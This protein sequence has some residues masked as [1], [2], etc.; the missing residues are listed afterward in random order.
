M[1]ASLSVNALQVNFE[2]VL[3]MEHEGMVKMKMV[4]TK[5]AFLVTFQ[6]PTDG[7]VGFTDLPAKEVVERKMVF[8]GTGV[9]F[10]PPNK[11]KD[12]KVEYRLLHDIVSKALYAKADSF[13][14]VTLEKLEIMVEISEGLKLPEANVEPTKAVEAQ[15]VTKECFIVVRSEPKKP[16]QQPMNF[17]GKSVFAPVEIREINWATHFLPKIDPTAKDKEILEAFARPN[18]MEEHCLLKK[19][20]EQPVEDED[21][22]MSEQQAQEQIE[23]ISR[24]V[25]NVEDTEAVNSQKHQVLGNN[26]AWLRPVSRGN[27]HFTVG[28]GR[29]RQ[30][31]PRPEGRLLRQTALE[32]LTRSARTETPRKVDRNKFRREGRRRGGARRRRRRL[33]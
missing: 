19:A 11:N 8:S 31:G 6:L 2:S 7:M 1:A 13:D 12:M 10:R 30:S 33:Y 24:F 20:Q 22:A 17:F 27:R 9:P 5:D 15:T 26:G 4:I 29:L 25:Q 3:S 32:G 14:V 23:E 21:N 18:P 16:T 28:G